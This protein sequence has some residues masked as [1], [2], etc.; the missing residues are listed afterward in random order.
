MI[1]HWVLNNIGKLVDGL[2]ILAVIILLAWW[3][4]FG[5]RFDGPKLKGTPVSVKSVRAIGQLITAE[6]YGE[7]VQSSANIF[8]VSRDSLLKQM[9]LVYNELRNSLAEIERNA[10]Y[11]ARGPFKKEERLSIIRHQFPELYDT[12]ECRDI[13][14]LT[15][16]DAEKFAL[17]YI[18]DN[19]W[20]TFL[21]RKYNNY[22]SNEAIRQEVVYVGRGWVKA[23]IDI[24]NFNVDNFSYSRDS[25]HIVIQGIVPEIIAADINPWF[26]PELKIK[27]F[28][29]LRSRG[30]RISPQMVS[31]VKE[32]CKQKLV[33]D[34]LVR[35][36]LLK[37]KQNAEESLK[38]LFTLVLQQPVN[39]LTLD[40]TKYQL[41]LK[42]VAFDQFVGRTETDF[43][44][45]MT[46]L[47]MARCDADWYRSLDGQTQELKEMLSRLRDMH[48]ETEDKGKWQKILQ[49][50]GLMP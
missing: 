13:F 44:Y 28:E 50:T 32:Q 10:D 43:L 27:G 24:Q 31:R 36:L 46:V 40:V 41:V 30:Q 25:Q 20:R 18:R 5:W 1:I 23:G 37:A 17:E 7:V 39:T 29:V 4:P 3:N 16:R 26:V 8:T 9:E 45:D 49:L 19:D 48:L 47:D 6:Y 15:G 2:I 22:Y 14:V 42:G 12:R 34:A 38:N 11:N 21:A 33:E 35:G